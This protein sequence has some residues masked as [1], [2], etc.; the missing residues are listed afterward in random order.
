MSSVIG[1]QEDVTNPP[2]TV[3]GSRWLTHRLRAGVGLAMAGLG[4]AGTFA[5]LT[6]GSL[7]LA[8]GGAEAL[9]AARSV[10]VTGLYLQ[11]LPALGFALMAQHFSR[12]GRLRTALGA[13]AM[14]G[15]SVA[16]MGVGA[17]QLLG[18]NLVQPLF[19]STALVLVAS[20]GVGATVSRFAHALR[21]RGLV[22]E[23]FHVVE[24]PE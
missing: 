7:W 19:L 24:A 21:N 20:V 2:Q 14:S 23:T 9:P 15:A 17:A 18:P 8:V 13:A 16:L 22:L 6:A 1:P 11:A 4:H 5:A 3:A 10:F 12:Y